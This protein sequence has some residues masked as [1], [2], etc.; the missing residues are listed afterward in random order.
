MELFEERKLWEPPILTV[1]EILSDARV[2]DDGF[3][4][5]CGEDGR[6]PYAGELEDLGGLELWC[7]QLLFV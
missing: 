7:G 2:R 3:Y 1:V 5:G 6:V 4:A